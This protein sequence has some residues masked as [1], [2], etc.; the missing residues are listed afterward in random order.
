MKIAALFFFF[1]KSTFVLME[2][3]IYRVKVALLG[4][5]VGIRLP[6]NPWTS[7]EIFAGF[8]AVFN[9]YTKR[10]NESQV[11]T[12]ELFHAKIIDVLWWKSYPVIFFCQGKE[13]KGYNFQSKESIYCQMILF[14]GI[15][16]HFL[17]KVMVS[18]QM[19]FRRIWFPAGGN[20]LLAKEINS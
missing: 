9:K 15:K 1:C 6:Q 13:F 14:L 11:L 3:F 19:T 18:C 5:E 12:Q 10:I 16:Y 7:I 4:P 8:H 2:N 20:T 17:S